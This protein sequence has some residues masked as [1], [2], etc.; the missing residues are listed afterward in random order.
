MAGE[1]CSICLSVIEEAELL[2]TQCRHVFHRLCLLKVMR[3][4]DECP[5][6]RQT[7]MIFCLPNGSAYR[8]FCEE[9]KAAIGLLQSREELEAIDR[10]KTKLYYHE[11]CGTQRVYFCV[12]HLIPKKYLYKPPKSWYLKFAKM[13]WDI[14]AEGQDDEEYSDD[15]D[16]IH[17]E[18]TLTFHFQKDK[19]RKVPE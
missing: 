8:R 12:D 13:G 11:M 5:C 10:I 3:F 6:C 18:V 16:R 19:K 17:D 7:P 9:T 2:Q 15:D 14:I 1:E 4:K